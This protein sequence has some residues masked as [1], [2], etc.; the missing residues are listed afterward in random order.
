MNLGG[1]HDIARGH[2]FTSQLVEEEQTAVVTRR[3]G[4]VDS[5]GASLAAANRD[6]R[7]FDDPDRFDS[8]QLHRES[9]GQSRKLWPVFFFI[10]ISSTLVGEGITPKEETDTLHWVCSPGRFHY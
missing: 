9:A 8:R 10:N 7:R 4:R 6:P 1:T 5:R 3:G 2:V